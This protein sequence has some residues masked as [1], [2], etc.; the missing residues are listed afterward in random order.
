MVD[1]GTGKKILR[2]ILFERVPREL[3]QRPKR[4]FGVPID[5]WLRHDLRSGSE[6]LIS[7]KK[8]MQQENFNYKYIERIWREHQSGK[9]NHA[10]RLWSIL[11]FQSWVESLQ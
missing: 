9:R 5:E 3:F 4:G 8:I 2:E 6:D 10:N 7:E 1:N 11:M